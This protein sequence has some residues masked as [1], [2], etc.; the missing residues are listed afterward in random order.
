[1]IMITEHFYSATQS[2]TTELKFHAEAHRQ[3]QVKNLPKVPRQG[4]ERAGF[5]P[6]LRS[7]GVDYTNAPLRLTCIHYV[8]S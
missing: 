2:T 8:L 6:T 5:E 1:M 3:L 7:R 4:L